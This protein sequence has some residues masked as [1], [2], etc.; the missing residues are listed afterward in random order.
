MRGQ[1]QPLFHLPVPYIPTHWRNLLADFPDL[2][3]CQSDTPHGNSDSGPFTYMPKIPLSMGRQSRDAEHR[4]IPIP[5]EV[6]SLYR[7]YRP[8]LLRRALNFEQALNTGAKIF[9]KYEG[10]DD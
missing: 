2:Q 9:I 6:L 1:K 5:H 4:Y 8:T 7:L 10:L 3:A